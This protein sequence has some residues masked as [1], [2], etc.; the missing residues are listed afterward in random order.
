MVSIHNIKPTSYIVCDTETTGLSPSRNSL[1]E[2]ALVKVSANKV[3]EPVSKLVKVDSV[4]TKIT[5]LTGITDKEV[6]K[7]GEPIEEVL[8][9]LLEET[10]AYYHIVGHNFFT[11]DHAFILYEAARISHPLLKV[12]NIDR[13]I[14]TAAL[15]KG[16]GLNI[17]R[18]EQDSHKDYARWVLRQQIPFSFRLDKACEDLGIDISDLDRHRAGGDSVSTYRLYDKLLSMDI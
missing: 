8:N 9:W 10:T 7:H 1:L 12:F 2:V 14:D 13:V 18:R 6:Q 5:E 16:Y 17:P 3:H 11:F 15:Y 4:P